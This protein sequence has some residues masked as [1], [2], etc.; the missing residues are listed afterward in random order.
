MKALLDGESVEM[1]VGLERSGQEENKVLS[2]NGSRIR[3]DRGSTVGTVLVARDTTEIRQLQQEQLRLNKIESLG[4]LA[5]GIAHDFN[6]LLCGILANISLARSAGDDVDISDC[7]VDLQKACIRAKG[8]TQQLLTFA[9]G[10]APIRE[11][12]SLADTIKDCARFSLQGSKVNLRLDIATDLHPVRADL[13]QI[14]QVIQNVVINAEQSMPDGGTLTI[15]AKNIDGSIPDQETHH[16]VRISCE[17]EGVGIEAEELSKIF[18]PYYSRKDNGHGLGLAISQSIVSKHDGQIRVSS[19]RGVGTR[20]E[21]DLPANPSHDL[22]K[23]QMQLG[24]VAMPARSNILVMDDQPLV[25]R[26]MVAILE[27]EGHR[28][29]ASTSSDEAIEE[30][31]RARREGT[32]IDVVILDLTIPGENGGASTLKELYR[33][34][35]GIRSI[36]SSGYCD[37][38]V[39]ADHREQKK[40]SGFF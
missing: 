21:I 5:G 18:D 16:F 23:D 38:P 35:P 34:D 10:G 8:L 29:F 20:L 17:D 32:P 26:S 7:L 3:D 1:E 24:P 19:K 33:I 2:I 4:I 37:D 40:G 30:L 9:K 27:A 6:N 36:V 22:G 11:W 13:Q 14:S 39:M 31:K 15:I 25:L 12:V 28:A